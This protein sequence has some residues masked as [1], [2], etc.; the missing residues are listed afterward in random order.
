MY[1]EYC[2]VIGEKGKRT[3]TFY[4]NIHREDNS[5][6]NELC[7]K[8]NV[9]PVGIEKKEVNSI[10][11]DEWYETNKH[12]FRLCDLLLLKIDVQGGEFDILKGATNVLKSC[13]VYGKCQ[14]EIECDEKFMK[15]LNINFDKINNIMDTNGFKCILRGYDS[16]F[17]PKET[18][19]VPTNYGIGLCNNLKNVLSSIRIKNKTACKLSL[20]NYT[21]ILHEIFDVSN[22]SYYDIYDRNKA[23]VIGRSSWRFAIFDTD[24]NVDQITNDTFSLM[25]PDFKD[26]VFFQNYKNNCIDFVYRPDLFHDIYTDYS[27]IFNEFIIK[28]EILDTI[29]TFY[30][31]HCNEHT[32]SIHVRSWNDDQSRKEKLDITKFYNK[33]NEF[34][35]GEHTFF[36]SS[37][38]IN[39]CYDIQNKFGSKIII[40]EPVE[41][42][43]PLLRAF[44][45]LY[46]LSKHSILIGTY[47]S[48]FTEMAYII[49]YS[50][51]KRIYIV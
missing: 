45:E 19:L 17:V 33:I 42:E 47:L 12:Q 48:T 1:I 39:I 2:A 11:L 23:T 31:K 7:C 14:V 22:T 27:N 13:S 25:F 43:S 36:V 9:M 41:N 3:T 8:G 28:K 38:D 4:S 20:T 30:K 21:N 44:I 29:E 16:V 37:D 35:T 40:Y 49:N 10:T 26:N 15:I 5:S 34:N 46:I 18:I 50:S 24:E 32:I 51:A 6:V